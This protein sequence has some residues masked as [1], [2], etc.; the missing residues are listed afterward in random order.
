MPRAHFVDVFKHLTSIEML[1][2]YE[3]TEDGQL[4][5][6]STLISVIRLLTG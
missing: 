2:E 1:L 6:I 5:H 3:Y 4:R